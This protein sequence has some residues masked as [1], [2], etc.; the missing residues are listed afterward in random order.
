MY[1]YHFAKTES[2]ISLL[3]F[4]TY[5]LEW[6]TWYTVDWLWPIWTGWPDLSI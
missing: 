2:K 6:T 4:L 1:I 5:L 3:F